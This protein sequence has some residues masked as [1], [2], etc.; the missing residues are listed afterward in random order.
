MIAFSVPS[1][2]PLDPVEEL[3]ESEETGMNDV[4]KSQ[5]TTNR[6]W[7]KLKLTRLLTLL[8]KW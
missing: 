7:L 3:I 1:L 4:I 5:Q 2:T 8:M 6:G